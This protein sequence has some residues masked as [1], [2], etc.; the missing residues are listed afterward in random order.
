[1]LD[2]IGYEGDIRHLLNRQI[3]NQPEGG[4]ACIQKHKVLRHNQPGSIFGNHVLL[5]AVLVL[6]GGHIILLGEIKVAVQGCAAMHLAQPAGII[7][8]NQVPANG[9]LGNP[10]LLSQLA[11]GGSLLFTQCLHDSGIPFF[12]KHP[13]QVLSLL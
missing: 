3:I 10:Q 13:H 9:R 5:A 4:G 11:D 7:Q 6:L 2:A 8:G 1:M 12:R